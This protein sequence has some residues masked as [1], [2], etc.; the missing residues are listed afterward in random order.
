MTD[1]IEAADKNT[2][3]VF[4][5][6]I[7]IYD[8]AQAVRD[9]AT[10]P[11]YYESRLVRLELDELG[12]QLLE[13]LDEDLQFEELSSTQN[14]YDVRL[15]TTVRAPTQF[16]EDEGQQENHEGQEEENDLNQDMRE[17][18]ICATKKGQ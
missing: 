5:N 12:R 7:D 1:M 10:V 4:G 13:E 9:G 6:Y 17:V 14:N 2:K 15:L 11:I 16:P 8:I 18:T 3:E